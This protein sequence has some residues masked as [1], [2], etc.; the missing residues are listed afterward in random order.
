MNILAYDGSNRTHWKKENEELCANAVP[1]DFN[2]FKLFV[3]NYEH[4]MYCCW[5]EKEKRD[6]ASIPMTR[7]HFLVDRGD[8][9]IM[10]LRKYGDF[11]T[12]LKNLINLYVPFHPDLL[13]GL[14]VPLWDEGDK[15]PEM[16]VTSIEKLDEQTISVYYTHPD[17]SP[18]QVS[19]DELGEDEIENI[20]KALLE[21][22]GNVMRTPSPMKDLK[23][24][25]DIVAVHISKP[26]DVYIMQDTSESHYDDV[27]AGEELFEMSVL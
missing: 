26:E 13:G 15:F 12:Y 11:K 16:L 18:M 5:L 7:E 27:F 3:Y 17:G 10:Y 21:R 19:V 22:D 25:K 20:L 9:I 23:K 1:F 14:E 2:V 6:I 4:W 24:P 8:G